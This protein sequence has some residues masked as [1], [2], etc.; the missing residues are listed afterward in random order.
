MRMSIAN[1][2]LM[3][4]NCRLAANECRLPLIVDRKVIEHRASASI[5]DAISPISNRPCM[6]LHVIM[7]IDIKMT[8]T[9]L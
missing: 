8:K 6:F 4:V 9:I 5:S 2:G 3:N 1:R 7:N